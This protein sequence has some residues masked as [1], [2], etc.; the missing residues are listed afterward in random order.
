MKT[1][2]LVNLI[3][4]M[5]TMC[6]DYELFNCPDKHTVGSN[7]VM[8]YASKNS[9]EFEGEENEIPMYGSYMVLYEKNQEN[10]V[11]AERHAMLTL[12]L[13][14]YPY[15]TWILHNKAYNTPYPYIVLIQIGAYLEEEI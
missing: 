11:E 5:K 3:L 14:E 1:E 15:I 9:M 10:A 13:E 8:N 4:E 6:E 2:N 12:N 7:L